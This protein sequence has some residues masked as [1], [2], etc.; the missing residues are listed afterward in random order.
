M[1][2]EFREW[3]WEQE[4]LRREYLEQEERRRLE[5]YRNIDLRVLLLGIEDSDRA[6][7]LLEWASRTAGAELPACDS[8]ND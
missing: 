7:R 6:E 5:Y 4:K 2:L 1:K 3:Y 8:S